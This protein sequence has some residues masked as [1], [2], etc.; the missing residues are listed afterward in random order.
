MFDSDK[1][2]QHYVSVFQQNLGNRIT[3]ELANGMIA[4]MLAAIP[5][6]HLEN[7]EGEKIN[8]DDTTAVASNEPADSLAEGDDKRGKRPR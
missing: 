5:T 8:V 1:I 7:G 2:R 3:P 6:M 4:V